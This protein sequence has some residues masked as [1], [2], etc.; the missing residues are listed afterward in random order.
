M[1]TP[2]VQQQ[3]M[4]KPIEQKKVRFDNNKL[5]TTI[6][7]PQ[8]LSNTQIAQVAQSALQRATKA[9]HMPVSTLYFFIT[10]LCIGIG[11]YLY[12]KYIAKSQQ[13]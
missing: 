8:T 1:Q 3:I 2:S 10:L 13:M 4:N 5:A 7:S 11:F 6:R 9:F 12:Q